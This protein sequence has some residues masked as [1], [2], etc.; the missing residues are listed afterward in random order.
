[1]VKESKDVDIAET[2][3]ARIKIVKEDDGYRCVYCSNN[4]ILLIY[5][6]WSGL[7]KKHIGN[8]IKEIK[9]VD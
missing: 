5:P 1:M 8:I 9:R 2:F 4:A 6:T 7:C 3:K